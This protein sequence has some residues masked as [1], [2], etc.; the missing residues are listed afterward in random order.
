VIDATVTRWQRFGRD[1]LYVTTPDG[2]PLGW[3]DLVSGRTHYETA[4]GAAVLDATVARWRES[5]GLP[6]SAAAGAAPRV[7]VVPTQPGPADG[8]PSWSGPDDLAIRPVGQSLADRLTEID[9]Q[10]AAVRAPERYWRT[11]LE[12]LRAQDRLVRAQAPLTDLLRALVGRPRPARRELR[13]LMRTAR[14]EARRHADE[15][16]PRVRELTAEAV[17]WQSGLDG[18]LVVGQMLAELVRKDPRWHVLHSVPVG[19]RGADIDHVLV[20][21]GGVLTLNTK[22]HPRGRVFVAHDA[23]LVNGT[24]YAY[25]RNSRHEA[26]R[27]ER[28]LSAAVGHR[29]VVEGVV[30]VRAQD[31]T[32]RAQPA[33]VHVVGSRRLVPWLRRRPDVLTPDEV[34]TVFAAA[35]R[36]TTWRA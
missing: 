4:D 34:E 11:E 26:Q 7:D 22:H 33:D 6:A 2:A 12:E 9:E 36:A 14:R 10:I 19:A 18:E 35:R 3:H 27:A 32:V 8:R 23:V 13:D 5:H 29:V 28:I 30:V 1:R 16:A 17:S 24:R 21:P 20:G 25:V 31:L 15:A